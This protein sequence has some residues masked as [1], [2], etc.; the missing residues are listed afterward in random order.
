MSAI[1]TT[2]SQQQVTP[3]N[4]M[5]QIETK[6]LRK[7]WKTVFHAVPNIVVFLLL[8][9]VMYLGHQ[10]DWKMPKFSELLGA[11]T[12]ISDDW[13]AEHLVPQ[14]MCI[15]CRNDLLPKKKPFGFCK[16]HGIA[17]CI[18]HHPELNQTKSEPK[19]PKYDTAKAIALIP[20]L[21]NNSRNTMHTNR[22]Q[23]TSIDSV[24]K[25]GIDVDV[26]QEYPMVDAIVANGELT[27][28]PT[29]VGHLSTRV[30]GTVVAVFKMLGEKVVADEIL[31]LVDAS[32]VGQAKSRLQQAVVQYQ[33]RRSTVERLIPIVKN[34]AVPEKSLIEAE[35]AL[36]EADVDLITA[37]QA[38]FNLG[39]ELPESLETK[40]SEYLAEQ[41]RFLDIPASIISS[42]PSGTKTANLI[43]IRAPHDGMLITVEVTAGEV[44]DTSKSLFNVSDPTR[45]WLLLN[46]RQEDAQYVHVGLPVRFQTDNGDQNASGQISWVSPAVDE[47]TRTLQVRIIIAN[48]DLLLRDKTFGKGRIILRDEP[49]AIVVPRESVQSTQDAHFVF[50]RDKNY[51]EDHSPK[52]FHVRQV[53]MGAQDGER[54]EILAGVLP[55]EVIASKGS[56]ILLAQLLR[57]SLGAGCGCHDH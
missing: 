5:T 2:S 29:R 54:V 24:V 32:Q 19:L 53:R 26:V 1:V 48:Q 38:L 43:P 13:C 14:T 22:V 16:V 56:N 6:Q 34:G 40:N 3:Q 17:E 10:T 31:A 33:L 25:A 4:N 21:G 23:F 45:M 50:V 9:S 44:I 52:Y 12:I 41:L 27:F 51:F 47:L 35:A 11:S 55:G 7:W 36:Q 39:Y 57:S 42:L 37:R 49:N 20:R 30:P 18:L 15:E 8:G 28:D 46:V